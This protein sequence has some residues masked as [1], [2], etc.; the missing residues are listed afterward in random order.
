MGR[1]ENRVTSFLKVSRV[2]APCS[3]ADDFVGSFKKATLTKSPGNPEMFTDLRPATSGLCPEKF[4]DFFLSKDLKFDNFD[5]KIKKIKKIN[6][7]LN[8]KLEA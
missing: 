7:K 6:I 5:S 3:L 4:S 2:A 8:K 1:V